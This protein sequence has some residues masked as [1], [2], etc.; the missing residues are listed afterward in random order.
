MKAKFKNK[1]IMTAIIS[2]VVVSMVSIGAIYAFLSDSTGTLTNM[3]SL[4]DLQTEIEE[5]VDGDLT[6]EPRVSNVGKTDALVRVRLSVS[7]TK[8]FSDNF[9]LEGIDPQ[10]TSENWETNWFATTSENKYDTYYYY[11][12]VLEAGTKTS[13]LFTKILKN[14]KGTYKDFEFIKNDDG[15]Y[16]PDNGDIEVLKLLNDISITFYQESI[17]TKAN[18]LVDEKKTTVNA[19]NADGT[20][21]KD[22]A[23]LLWEYFDSQK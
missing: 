20:L 11:N 3:F 19:V 13:P 4:S 12:G 6:K 14:D 15:T 18:I 23:K 10:L 2:L 16:T 17:P 1:K 21:N 5:K 9:G 8:L 7:N 22:N